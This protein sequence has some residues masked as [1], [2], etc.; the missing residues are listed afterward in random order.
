MHLPL[1]I[2]SWAQKCRFIEL[3]TLKLW[4]AVGDWHSLH[5][6]NPE[7]WG[8]P[9]PLWPGGWLHLSGTLRGGGTKWH[10]RDVD[11]TN[12]GNTNNKWHVCGHQ[13][14][15][16]IYPQ[17]NVAERDIVLGLC[18]SSPG[19]TIWDKREGVKSVCTRYNSLLAC[20]YGDWTHHSAVTCCCTTFFQ[21]AIK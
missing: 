2:Y 15:V 4:A 5:K 16:N 13:E 20:N 11:F 17:P 12:I 19:S 3:N 1:F 7:R 9:T 10:F 21:L 14:G 18:N 6:S 8:S